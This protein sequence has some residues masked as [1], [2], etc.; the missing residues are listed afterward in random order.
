MAQSFW[1]IRA[2]WE[3]AVDFRP[4][5]VQAD[6]IPSN[7]FF[8]FSFP[9]FSQ[10]LPVP[11]GTE[12]SQALT[13]LWRPP[14]GLPYSVMVAF[15]DIQPQTVGRGPIRPQGRL[16]PAIDNCLRIEWIEFLPAAFR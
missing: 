3:G 7:L 11:Q 8:T 2:F 9:S 13:W 5:K 15:G 16:F 10:A 14:D 6:E 4:P 12:G 1:L